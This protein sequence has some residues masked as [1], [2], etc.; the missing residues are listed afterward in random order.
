MFISKTCPA[1]PTWPNWETD[2][3]HVM[4]WF[5]AVFRSGDCFL[6]CVHSKAIT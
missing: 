3:Y 5:W 1:E 4:R 6:I 2:N